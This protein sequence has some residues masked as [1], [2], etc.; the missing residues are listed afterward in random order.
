VVQELDSFHVDVLQKSLFMSSCNFIDGLANSVH[1]QVSVIVR[2][3]L[4]IPRVR[5][6]TSIQALQPDC[7][8]V[9]CCTLN[10]NSFFPEANTFF[11][12]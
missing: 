8:V 6:R 1:N 12:V 11:H 10:G 5:F 7:R 3:F 2:R 9:V 4:H